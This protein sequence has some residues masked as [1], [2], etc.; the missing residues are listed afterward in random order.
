[1]SAI[2][3]ELP[4]SIRKKLEELARKEGFSV[5]QFIASAAS[6]KLAVMLQTDFLENEAKRGTRKAFEKFL[7]AVPDA[8][9][10]HPD[11]VIK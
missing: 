9:P 4:N 3:V 6:E 1:M 7:A 10:I 2:T 8:E 5:E 11:D